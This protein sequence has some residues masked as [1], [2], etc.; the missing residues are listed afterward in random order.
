MSDVPARREG[1]ADLVPVGVPVRAPHL[2]RS[3]RLF[4]LAS[5]ALLA[6]DVDGGADIPFV[7]EEH[8]GGARPLYEY[9]PL[10]GDYVEFSG[11][12]DRNGQFNA[13]SMD[14]FEPRR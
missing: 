5:F 3:L 14:R 7:F 4:A 11:G 12:W 2:H 8:D 9:R 1:G 10:V 13:D 6:R